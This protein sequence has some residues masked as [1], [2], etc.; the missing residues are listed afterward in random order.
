[1]A[2]SANLNR[3]R[4]RFDAVAFYKLNTEGSQD[5]EK[6]DFVSLEVD[7][8]YRFLHTKYPGPTASAKLG[9]Q[10]RHDGRDT[11]SGD[12]LSNTGTTA[13]LART[14]ITWHP[15][16]ASDVSLSVDLPIHQRVNGK[17]LGLD[18]RVFVAVGIR[19]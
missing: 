6:G 14:G 3:G 4:A 2:V 1:M 19:F 7:A 17:Q 10:W 8:A 16:P 11:T 13:L 12:K 18:N 15:T 9:L 5:F